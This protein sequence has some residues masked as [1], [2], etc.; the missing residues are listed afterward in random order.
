M[1]LQISKF[2]SSCLQNHLSEL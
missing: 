2:N 1:A